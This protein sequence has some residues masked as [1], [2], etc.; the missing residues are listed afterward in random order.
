MLRRLAL[1][2]L[3]AALGLFACASSSNNQ[4]LAADRHPAA[5]TRSDTLL[6]FLP[7]AGDPPSA[8]VE[9]D[10]IAAVRESRVP[11]DM[12]AVDAHAGY[13]LGRTLVDRLWQDIISPAKSAGY[14]EIWLV[15]ISMGGLGALLFAQEH[16]ESIDGIILLAPYLG[17]KRTLRTIAAVGVR[18][19]QPDRQS[20]SFDYELW[21]WLKGYQNDAPRPQLY[22][23]YGTED[24]NAKAHALL[25]KLLPQEQIFT[26]PGDH[27]W[28]VWTPLWRRILAT[29]EFPL[30]A[31]KPATSGD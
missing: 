16:G 2:S 28:T 3:A 27:E 8:F 11:V 14:G 18:E 26:A 23:G 22:L 5:A 30:F 4:A 20:G 13:Y 12:L 24:A 1:L 21:R 9:H 29:P 15:G 6:V 17:K 31:P 7:G 10:F 25:A 19:W